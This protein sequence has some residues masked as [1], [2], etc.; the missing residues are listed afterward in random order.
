MVV[1]VIS[2]LLA[3]GLS[4]AIAVEEYGCSAASTAQASPITLGT[5][6]AGS[7]SV[8]STWDYGDVTVG[9]G[10]R[11]NEIA[12]ATVSA[13]APPAI[14]GSG[15][16]SATGTSATVVGLT[17]SNADDLIYVSVSIIGTDSVSSVTNSGTALTW[18]QRGALTDGSDERI[19]TWWA[20]APTADTR[21]ITVSFASSNTFIVVAFGIS[22]VNTDEPFDPNLGSPVT[23]SGS[24]TTQSVTLSTV[25]PNDLLIG[26]IAVKVPSGGAPAPSAGTG[27]T[28][29][30]STNETTLGGAAEYKQ[31]TSPQTSTTIDFS[32]STSVTWAMIGDAVQ[33]V[34]PSVSS[35]T[36]L[37]DPASSGSF[38]VA[39]GSSAFLWSPTYSSAATI[40]SGDWTLDLWASATSQGSMDVLFLVLSGDS[41][42]ALAASGSTEAIPT[43]KSE[44]ISTF[45]APETTVPSGDRLLA[46][47]TNPTGSGIT[48]TIYWGTGQVTY[49]ETTSDYDYVLRLINS[50]LVDY[51]VSLSVYS[52]SS[53]GR[54]VSM[55]VYLYSP[56]TAEIVIADGDVTQSSGATMTL[57]ASSTLYVQ[58]Q[59]SANAHGSS[60]VVVY[61]SISPGTNPFSYYVMDITV[62]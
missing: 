46:V 16:V 31:V 36:D 21:D 30:Q 52:Y 10:L 13:L 25:N 27:Y 48:F 51:S 8:S 18:S 41:V 2:I 12:D 35:N 33:G 54:I 50:G 11:F 43:S 5:G 56:S 3:V 58:I 24:G 4:S 49:F 22:G 19:E 9:A 23:G 32:T 17:T 14:D 34:L 39:A 45:A 1:V 20:I 37:A 47:L 38:T 26:A 61:V 62:I 42:I 29:I 55:T 59:A 53:I 7:S 40:Y 15:V 28:T 6:I 44:V 57:S 60:S